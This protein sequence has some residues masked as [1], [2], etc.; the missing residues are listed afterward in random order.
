MEM[1]KEECKLELRS[2]ISTCAVYDR[3]FHWHEY[4]ELIYIME[5]SCRFFVDG[6][7]IKANEGDLISINARGVHQFIVDVPDTKVRTIQFPIKILL[8]ISQNII[9]LK[10]YITAREIENIPG[11]KEKLN[12]IFLLMDMENNDVRFM[13]DNLFLQSIF[14][15]LYF[16]LM[17]YFPESHRTKGEKDLRQDFYRITE[18]INKHYLC[19][20]SVKTLSHELFIP[21]RKIT[22][23]FKKYSGIELKTYVNTLRIKKAN[24]L[25]N[26]GFN[27]TNAALCSGFQCVRS[28]NNIYKGYMGITPSEYIKLHID[29]R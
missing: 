4:Y 2:H 28:F 29:S 23:L 17:K 24:R 21:E 25:L 20:V 3:P 11:L 1:H 16:I 26:D 5:N 6:R 12:N 7:L 9:P 22:K 27:I 15:S 18:Y 8:N 14:S 13:S 19:D 10:T